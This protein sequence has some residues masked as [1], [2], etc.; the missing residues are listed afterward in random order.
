VIERLEKDAKA[1]E[2]T[3][4]GWKMWEQAKTAKE[5]RLA[6]FLKVGWLVGWWVYGLVIV[7]L[8][9]SHIQPVNRPL[10]Q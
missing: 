7:T 3:E 9:F 1:T 4:G 8:L 10:G 2:A 6:E 5:D